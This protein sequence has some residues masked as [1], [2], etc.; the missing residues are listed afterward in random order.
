MGELF[1]LTGTAAVVTG[2]SRRIG[3]A[4]ARVLIRQGAVVLINGH[5]ESETGDDFPYQSAG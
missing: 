1:D 2:S 3:P 5:D 4:I